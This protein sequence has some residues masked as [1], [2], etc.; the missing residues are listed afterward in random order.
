MSSNTPTPQHA[1]LTEWLRGRVAFYLERPADAIDPDVDLAL[2]G[3]DSLYVPIVISEI[4]DTLHVSLDTTITRQH[5]TIN[6]LVRH[7]EGLLAGRDP[8][9]SRRAGETS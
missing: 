5:S 7:V 2:Y 1:D 6:A 3:M 4:E 9:A 8:S